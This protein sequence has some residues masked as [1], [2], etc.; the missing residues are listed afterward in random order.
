M[1][2][3][4]NLEVSLKA[5]ISEII[6]T[7]RATF[8]LLPASP[9][10]RGTGVSFLSPHVP[11]VLPSAEQRP[12]CTAVGRLGVCGHT[13]GQRP[14][15]QTSRASPLLTNRTASPQA[16]LWAPLLADSGTVF[17]KRHSLVRAR[18]LVCADTAGGP[19]AE[20]PE[21]T[22]G[23]DQE[24]SEASAAPPRQAAMGFSHPTVR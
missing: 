11:A 12:H 9:M 16:G 7:Y 1:G 21:G 15:T 13:G 8:K 20:G 23:W 6:S 4:Q 24:P 3:S 10:L 17:H 19:R 18:G 5:V 2:G 14:A 22:P